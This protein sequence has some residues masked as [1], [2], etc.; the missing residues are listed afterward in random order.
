MRAKKIAALALCSALLLSTGVKVNAKDYYKKDFGF[1]EESDSLYDEIKQQNDYMYLDNCGVDKTKRISSKKDFNQ[2][3][4]NEKLE[5]CVKP[6]K[7]AD[8]AKAII[9]LNKKVAASKM[10]TSGD[11]T[12]STYQLSGKTIVV[13]EWGWD[14]QRAGVVYEWR[15]TK[16]KKMKSLKKE[17]LKFYIA[18][19]KDTKEEGFCIEYSKQLSNHYGEKWP[20]NVS[21]KYKK[22]A[23]RKSISATHITYE[24]FAYQGNKLKKTGTDNYYY[25]SHAYE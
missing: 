24:K 14:Q 2:D 5:L 3:G 1:S 11:Y 6:M 10:T 12:I 18:S 22:Y 20:K 19:K 4:K 15:G 8:K 21:K 7:G 17:H 25:V 23:K 9:K 13:L 16:F